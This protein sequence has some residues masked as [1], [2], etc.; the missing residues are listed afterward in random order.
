[1]VCRHGCRAGNKEGSKS[2]K[3]RELHLAVK[4]FA[5]KVGFNSITTSREMDKVMGCLGKR[6]EV[7][8]GSGKIG[9]RVAVGPFI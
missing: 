8:M 3:R 7:L 2:N 9:S 1:M 5:S 6:S 4:R